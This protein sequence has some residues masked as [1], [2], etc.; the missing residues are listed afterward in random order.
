[1][2]AQKKMSIAKDLHFKC[3]LM[4]LLGDDACLEKLNYSNSMG[5][6]LHAWKSLIIVTLIIP[7]VFSKLLLT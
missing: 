1:M 4:N 5:D 3:S 2:Y 7:T 6:S